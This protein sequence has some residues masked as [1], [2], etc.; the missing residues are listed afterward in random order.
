MHMTEANVEKIRKVVSTLID[1]KTT[2][3]ERDETLVKH[4][5]RIGQLKDDIHLDLYKLTEAKAVK[6]GDLVMIYGKLYVVCERPFTGEG[7][8]YTLEEK[9]YHSA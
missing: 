8:R 9:P 4:N 5:E 3:K 7:Y 6:L 2:E 1:L